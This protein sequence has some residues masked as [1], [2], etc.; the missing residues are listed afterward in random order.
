MEKK[1]GRITIAP[2]VL[3]TIVRLT[4]L[5]QPGVHRM[6]SRHGKGVGRMFSSRHHA[7]DEGVQVEVHDDAVSVDVWIVARADANMLELGQTLQSE[8]TR[9]IHDMVGMA[10][11]EVNIHID[12]VAFASANT[13]V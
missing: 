8:I 5:A 1:I 12:D 7:V 10:V 13:G 3:T 11:R 4:T 2:N 9:A 6:S